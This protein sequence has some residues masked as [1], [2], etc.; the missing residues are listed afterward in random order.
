MVAILDLPGEILHDIACHL[1]PH[2]HP[3]HGQ[4]HEFVAR[5]W[6]EASNLS[7]LDALSR[8]CTKLRAFAQPVLYHC[9]IP[10]YKSSNFVPLVRTL[11]QCPRLAHAVKEMHIGSW[12]SLN[13]VLP[14]DDL[15]F[16]LQHS[17][18]LAAL[19]DG[20]PLKLDPS[21]HALNLRAAAPPVLSDFGLLR[22]PGVV[23][24]A[25]A[26]TVIRNVERV[27]I[28]T[29]IGWD[30]V[31]RKAGSL[32]KLTKLRIRYENESASFGLDDIAGLLA[33]APKLKVLD[34]NGVKGGSKNVHHPNLKKL[35][36]SASTLDAQ[37]LRAILG[38]CEKLESFT[39]HWCWDEFMWDTEAT[40]RDIT[41]AVLLRKD[42]LK[43]LCLS[44]FPDF[45]DQHQMMTSLKRMQVLETID[46]KT[47]D[48][49]IPYPGIAGGSSQ[50]LVDFLPRSIVSLSLKVTGQS[51][52]LL[53]EAIQDFAQA[54]PASFPNLIRF[55]FLC[56]NEIQRAEIKRIASFPEK[57]EVI[58]RLADYRYMNIL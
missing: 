44:F 48:L 32:P 34:V 9:P 50:A 51:S 13:T 2:C 29:H 33:A 35:I 25:L 49:F 43:H 7:G 22:K 16:F 31:L 15:R 5:N 37:D 42:T 11:L 39:Y 28:Q 10:L 18:S 36:L 45:V 19:T 26:L 53:K 12:E 1:C 21:W 47:S 56:F 40:P 57:V 54:V 6:V 24:A 30:L 3:R 17:S 23:L 41:E 27:N 38:G 52:F 14:D 58:V 46:V 8:T 55:E 20:R 4:H